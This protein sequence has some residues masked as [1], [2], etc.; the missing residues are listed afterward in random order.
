[1]LITTS[2]NKEALLNA[3][4]RK[5]E[6][7]D[8]EYPDTLLQI[9]HYY[10]LFKHSSE[11]QKTSLIDYFSTHRCNPLVAAALVRPGKQANKKLFRLIKDHYMHESGSSAWQAEIMYSKWWLP[12]FKI[13]RYDSH[14]YDHF[15]KSSNF[16]GLFKLFTPHT[17]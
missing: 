3:L 5:Q 17:T 1:M 11:V 8:T 12:L 10:V 7:V 2:G 14:D 6:K 16:P 9:W 4:R 13:A 15:M